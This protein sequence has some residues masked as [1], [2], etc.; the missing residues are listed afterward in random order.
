MKTLL[1]LTTTPTLKLTLTLTLLSFHSFSQSN[2]A[3]PFLV[4][5]QVDS[6]D[7]SIAWYQNMMGF[8]LH[9]KKEFSDYGLKIAT[10]KSGDFE[11]ELVD[12]V[13]SQNKS[14]ALKKL[15]ADEITGFAKIAFRV[16]DVSA[17]H[18]A[19]KAKGA[20]FKVEL[21]DSNINPKEKFFIVGDADGNWVQIV[22]SK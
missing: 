19:L 16:D 3:R 18:R 14:D 10:M 17:K 6:L 1:T 5:I 21:R 13:K 20:E 9:D 2:N 15:Q 7:R 4:A 8:T 12:N 22:G 11:L